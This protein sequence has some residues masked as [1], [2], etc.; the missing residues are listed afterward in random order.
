MTH[1]LFDLFLYR[2]IFRTVSPRPLASVPRWLQ[3][4]Q[5]STATSSRTTQRGATASGAR[6][7]RTSSPRCSCRARPP[8]TAT[9]AVAVPRWWVAGL[10]PGRCRGT[11]ATA[12]SGLSPLP[13]PPTRPR[14]RRVRR[15]RPSR[16]AASA[17][18]RTATSATSLQP[19]LPRP[20]AAAAAAAAVSPWRR[21]TWTPGTSRRVSPL[22]QPWPP[23]PIRVR[24]GARPPTLLCTLRTPRRRLSM[25]Q[26]LC[27]MW[28]L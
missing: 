3:R 13:R 17:L 1:A 28:A 19:S 15:R 27:M 25:P 9:A 7:A 26:R 24:R 14:L 5:T 10:R 12:A 2:F 16:G 6:W 23:S 11:A 4:P 21:S 18:E 20:T 22:W 8:S